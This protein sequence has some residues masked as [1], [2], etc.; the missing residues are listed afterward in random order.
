MARRV[1]IAEDNWLTPAVLRTELQ[2]HGYDVIGI[3]RT[4]TEA[5]EMSR[6][7]Q[8]DVVLMDIRMPEMDGIEVT[9]VLMEECPSCVVM[10]TGDASLSQ[11]SEEAGAMGY[12]VKPFLPDEISLAVEHA[13]ER[14]S[15]FQHVRAGVS[16]SH[17]VREA[18]HCVRRAL[19]E[20][21]DRDRVNEGEAFARLRQAAAAQRRALCETAREMVAS[22]AQ[23]R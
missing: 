6:R 11:V 4:G 21:S 15:W 17:E 12:L 7:E 9:R 19:R 5:L 20:I 16:E 10:V 1:I 3:A 23:P 2:A 18:W 8:P 22:Q 13:L 14:F